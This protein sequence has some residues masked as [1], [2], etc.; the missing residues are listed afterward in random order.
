LILGML[1]SELL[2]NKRQGISLEVA[3]CANCVY[4]RGQQCRNPLSPLSD[5]RVSPEGYCPAF[6]AVDTEF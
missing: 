3:C 6:E 5:R 4:C 1:P 2:D